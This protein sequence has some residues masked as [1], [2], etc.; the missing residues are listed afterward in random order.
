MPPDLEIDLLFWEIGDASVRAAFFE[1]DF[2]EN[3][4]P[5][6]QDS[7][8]PAGMDESWLARRTGQSYDQPVRAHELVRQGRCP[9]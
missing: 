2:G 3:P 7:I 9:R 5:R 1:N 6:R 8:G 4:P